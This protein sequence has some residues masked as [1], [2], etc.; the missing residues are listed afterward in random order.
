[1]F[2]L[3][4][5]SPLQKNPLYTSSEIQSLFKNVIFSFMVGMQIGAATMENSVKVLQKIKK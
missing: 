4:K 2:R 3:L 5:I 1:M